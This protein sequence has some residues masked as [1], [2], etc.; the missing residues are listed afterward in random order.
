[1]KLLSFWSDPVWRGLRIISFVT[2]AITLI[3]LAVVLGGATSFRVPLAVAVIT[4]IAVALAVVIR[5][6]VLH[7]RLRHSPKP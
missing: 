3:I 1:M 2:A 6:F 4:N 5:T 7:A